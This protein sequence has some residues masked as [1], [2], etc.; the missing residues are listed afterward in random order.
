MRF[1]GFICYSQRN[2]YNTQ[3][4]Y[5]EENKSVSMSTVNLVITYKI[6]NIS[7]SNSKSL[8]LQQSCQ[9]AKRMSVCFIH[10]FAESA[11][12]MPLQFLG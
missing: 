6:M 12:T 5:I 3:L 1:T 11:Q 4:R 9:A 2:G 8:E 7:T 10:D